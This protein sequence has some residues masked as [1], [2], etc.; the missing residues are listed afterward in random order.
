[1]CLRRHPAP[2]LQPLP[3]CKGG[4]ATHKAFGVA[5]ALTQE[6]ACSTESKAPDPSQGVA[7]TIGHRQEL[8]TPP[9]REPTVEAYA[10]P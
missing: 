3:R 2:Q 7:L 1:M 8:G 6:E 9:S 5:L 4:G 10:S